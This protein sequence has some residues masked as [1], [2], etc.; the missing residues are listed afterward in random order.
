MNRN[1]PTDVQPILISKHVEL[2]PLQ[3]EHTAPLLR[4]AEDGQLWNNKWTLVPDEKK[5]IPASTRRLQVDGQE[6]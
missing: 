3:R 6:P 2:Q 5:S 4:A 1:D